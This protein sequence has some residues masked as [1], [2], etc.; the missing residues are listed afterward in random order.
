MDADLYR[1]HL[2][3]LL[4]EEAQALANLQTLLDKEYRFITSD[5]LEALD[6]AGREREQCITDLM[7]IDADRQTLCRSTG[8]DADKAGLLS[9]IQW[10]DPSGVL[11]TRWSQSV[12]SIRHCRSLN[13]R[14][15]ALVRNRMQRVETL[16]D[17]LG[18][19]QG[20]DSRTY[21]ARGNAYAQA[22]SGRVCSIQA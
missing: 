9:L 2:D 6:A 1:S 13:D 12:N 19:N 18:V 8:R 22:S 15:G 21:T 7:R 14:N 20:R 10:C 17:T 11:R 4:S 5:D 3:N 16:L